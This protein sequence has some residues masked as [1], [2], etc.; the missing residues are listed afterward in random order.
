[1]PCMCGALDCKECRGAAA[2]DMETYEEAT[3]PEV[4]DPL[5]LR[6]LRLQEFYGMLNN[7]GRHTFKETAESEITKF[8]GNTT[9]R[10]ADFAD[11][12]AVVEA[13]IG[14]RG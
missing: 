9:I 11:L 14:E 2:M 3:M 13:L 1:M 6:A 10:S 12:W 4:C 5:L 7:H 8:T